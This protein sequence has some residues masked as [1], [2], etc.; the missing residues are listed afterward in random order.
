M[1]GESAWTEAGSERGLDPLAMLGSIEDLYQTQLL[2]GFSSVTTRLRY[3]SFHAWWTTRYTDEVYDTDLERFQSWT[4]RLEALYALASAVADR[5]EVGLAGARFARRRAIDMDDPVDFRKETDRA[6]PSEARYLK[7]LSGAFRQIYAGQMRDIGILGTARAH[8]LPVPTE[9]GRTLADGFKEATGDLGDLL[10]EGAEAGTISRVNLVRL[11]ALRPSVIDQEGPEGKALR[12]LL[13]GVTGPPESGARRGASL[14]AILNVAK[15]TEEPVTPNLLRWRWAEEDPTDPQ[16]ET[17][18]RWQ[19]YQS[20]DTLRV[21][22]EALLRYATLALEDYPAGLPPSVLARRLSEETPDVSLGVLMRAT[23]EE[24]PDATLEDLQRN[25]LTQWAGLAE[26]MAP[27]ARLVAM[28][29]GRVEELA[30]SFPGGAA[31]QN[32]RTELER[33]EAAWDEPAR[34]FLAGLIRERIVMR[35]LQVSA[36]KF[37]QQNRYTFLVE[38]ESDRLLARGVRDVEPS[39]PRL[40]TAI[41]FLE[42]AGLLKD[43]FITPR[44]AAWETEA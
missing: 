33:I 10:W 14:R 27:L 1:D 5:D 17:L 12:E 40:D 16:A 9:L 2:P 30:I 44:G 39:G 32:V 3:Y 35:H 25:A 43:G 15:V 23:N 34:T 41:Q 42:D 6:T 26:I 24:R 8:A 29:R 31:R 11:G 37:H 20:G 21:V 19:H 22:Y 28:W 13:M 7:P 18:A 36:R 4:R 38:M